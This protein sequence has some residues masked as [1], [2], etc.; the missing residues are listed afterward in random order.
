VG[1]AEQSPVERRDH[2]AADDAEL[3]VTLK[4]R[5]A[6][7]A[8]VFMALQILVADAMFGTYGFGNGWVLPPSAVVAWLGSVVAEVIG[9]VL[10]VTRSLFPRRRRRRRPG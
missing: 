4:R 3:D 2:A 5:V 8:L 10:V 6:N 1:T 7:T 9:V